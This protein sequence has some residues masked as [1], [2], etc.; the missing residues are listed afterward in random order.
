MV[1]ERYHAYNND[2]S[3]FLKDYMRRG[4]ISVVS[5]VVLGG[6]VYG[7]ANV[8][9]GNLVWEKNQKPQEFSGTVDRIVDSPGRDFNPN[10]D[11]LVEL[12]GLEGSIEMSVKTARQLNIGDQL[13]GNIRG[14]WNLLGNTRWTIVDTTLT[15]QGQNPQ[16]NLPR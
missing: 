2:E 15:K 13:Q 3:G 6:I 7:L 14:E 1:G 9:Y 8:G 16:N 10:N 11:V 12:N 5:T 4:I